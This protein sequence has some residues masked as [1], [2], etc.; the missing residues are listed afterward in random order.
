MTEHF[1][2]SDV[3]AP[4]AELWRRLF[5]A[6]RYLKRLREL[7]RLD[8]ADRIEATPRAVSASS[9]THDSTDWRDGACTCTTDT[10]TGQK[11]WSRIS[12][13]EDH[14]TG[15]KLRTEPCTPTET[16]ADAT[17]LRGLVAEHGFVWS[18]GPVTAWHFDTKD[19]DP[20]VPVFLD[21]DDAPSLSIGRAVV[22]VDGR[23][24]LRATIT[25]GT[26]ARAMRTRVRLARGDLRGLSPRL[27][28]FADGSAK[29]IHV[30]VCNDPRN[31]LH[32]LDLT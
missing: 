7:H 12:H 9:D 31:P 26:D 28:H 18:R 25:L 11:T 6:S 17:E 32:C 5:V 4:N 19:P 27:M 30:V 29:L 3:E 20:S 24:D 14:E 8:A 13:V 16:R 2:S 1:D 10:T 21:H 15:P 23:G 22:R